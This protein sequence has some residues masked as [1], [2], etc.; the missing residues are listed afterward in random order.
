M[1]EHSNLS[2]KGVIRL[3]KALAT[4]EYQSTNCLEN[5]FKDCKKEVPSC[6]S[7]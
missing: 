7:C 5:I 1:L 6:N 3:L 2:N 4:S